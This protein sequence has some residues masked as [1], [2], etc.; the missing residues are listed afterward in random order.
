MLL[1]SSLCNTFSIIYIPLSTHTHTHP[2]RN[3]WYKVLDMFLINCWCINFHQS[4]CRQILLASEI[5]VLIGVLLSF[6]L[7]IP[8][9]VPQYVCSG[10]ILFVSAEVLEGE[11]LFG[12]ITLLFMVSC[13]IRICMKRGKKKNC[14]YEFIKPTDLAM[15]L[16]QD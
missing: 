9:S 13:K 1:I 6:H 4:D 14:S 2:Q 15:I 5:M 16:C 10:L 7:F 11:I 3:I 8:Y 12:S